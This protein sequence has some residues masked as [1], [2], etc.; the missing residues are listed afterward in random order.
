MFEVYKF[1]VSAVIGANFGDEGKGLVTDWLASKSDNAIVVLHNGGPQ[2]AHT[3]TTPEGR[4]HIFRH[5]GAGTFSGAATY[6]A[7]SFIC[8][9]MIFKEE[10]EKLMPKLFNRPRIYIDKRCKFTT[11]YDMIINQAREIERGVAKHGSCGLGIYETICR[12]RDKEFVFQQE[13]ISPYGISIGEFA[14]LPYL[15]KYDYLKSLKKYYTEKRIDQ[16]KIHKMPVELEKALESEVAIQNYISDFEFMMKKCALVDGP[17]FLHSY[18]DVIFENGQ[19]LLL[20]Q[21]N[22]EYYPHL[23][24]SHTGLYN[25][26]EI[27]KECYFTGCIN[28]YYVSRTYMTRHG[29]GRFD[30]ECEKKDINFFMWDRTN[31]PNM[32]QDTLRYGTLDYKELAA[33]IASESK[34]SDYPVTTNLVLTHLNEYERIDE[35]TELAADGVYVSDGYTRNSIKVHKLLF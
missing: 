28:T 22:M 30:T 33:R 35:H 32:F 15:G 13:V 29:A 20:D 31:V 23:T 21:D 25:I 2:R 12:Y 5:I 4:E 9:P 19:G 24:P 10:Y 6:I 8:N 26:N 17:D 11:F 27:L 18:D 1:K 16:T 3:V 7:K 14:A 34:K